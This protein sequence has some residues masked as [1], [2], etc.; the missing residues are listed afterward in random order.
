MLVGAVGGVGDVPVA[1]PVA[2]ADWGEVAAA[3]PVVQLGAGDADGVAEFTGWHGDVGGQSFDVVSD[4]PVVSVW[5]D[6]DVV[7][8]TVG[9]WF[10]VGWAV[11]FVGFL[12][13]GESS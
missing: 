2:V 12:V 9:Q 13:S 11:W 4:G 7:G 10:V 8:V 1:L 6:H 5:A 3:G